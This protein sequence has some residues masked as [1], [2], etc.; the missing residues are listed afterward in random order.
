MLK[1]KP[2]RELLQET[3]KV[4]QHAISSNIEQ[5][6]PAELT[7]YLEDD[8]FVFSGFKTYNQLREASL[9]LQDEKGGFKPFETFKQDVKKI[10]DTYNKSY[11]EAEYEFAVG[12]SQ[13]AAKWA[14]IEED[15]DEY[16]LQYR[17]SNDGRVRPEHA[18][19][20][21]ITLP[22]SDPFWDKYYPPNGW[23]CRCTVAQVRKGKHER[24]NS[25]DAQ[26]RGATA[27]TKLDKNGNNRSEMF[28]FNP[29]KEKVIFPATHPYRTSR[30]AG[31][32]L[33]TNLSDDSANNVE[34][35]EAC[36]VI[37]SMG[38]GTYQT[39][40]TTN[41]E[42]RVNTQHGKGEKTVN[43]EIATYFAEKYG[44]KIDLLPASL[45]YKTPDSFNRTLGVFQE[46]KTNK[47][48]TG[49]AIDREIRDA[50]NQAGS[51]V[52]NVKSGIVDG[53]LR[54]AIQDRVKRSKNITDITVIRGGND[55][56]Y[57]RN[58]IIKDG[59]TL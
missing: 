17:T 50:K 16:D 23:N 39:H 25:E 35:C 8:V 26:Q 12:S 11:L 10:D 48:P 30:C 58:E 31:C 55:K 36:N 2:A 37:R 45:D 19:L 9:L 5:K 22:P 49:S 33:R 14:Q 32:G 29:G 20:H 15:G 54:N 4:L 40:P 52:V 47:F 24:S 3:N 51:I 41:G 56:R 38:I 57:F 46:Y 27:T 18:V 53:D 44:H 6:I 34:R 7:R 43:I 21:N 1:E 13:M 42:V 59:F 28:R